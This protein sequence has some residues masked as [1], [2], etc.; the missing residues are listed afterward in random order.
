[1]IRGTRNTKEKKTNGIGGKKNER[2][3]EDHKRTL[4]SL[5]FLFPF[6]VL[7][8]QK[9]KKKCTHTQKGTCPERRKEVQ[10]EVQKKKEFKKKKPTESLCLEPILQTVEYTKHSA[11][12]SDSTIRRTQE[13]EKTEN[14]KKQR[15]E[16]K[17]PHFQK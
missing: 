2:K 11:E 3:N 13:K 4:I 5:Y 17:K 1:M 9:H 14:S 15:N 7:S 10:K 8:F 12:C 16:K 6:F